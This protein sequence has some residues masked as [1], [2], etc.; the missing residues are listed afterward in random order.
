MKNRQ[1]KAGMDYEKTSATELEGHATFWSTTLQLWQ[2]SVIARC[3]L[4]S[5]LDVRQGYKTMDQGLGLQ[6]RKDLR[7]SCKDVIVL[8]GLACGLLHL[9]FAEH[10]DIKDTAIAQAELLDKNLTELEIT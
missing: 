6:R 5:R 3:R 1:T 8:S 2:Q 9:H 4:G 10:I 7:T